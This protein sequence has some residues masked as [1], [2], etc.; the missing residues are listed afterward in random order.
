M[1]DNRLTKLREERG[2]NMKQVAEL[3]EITYTTYVGYEKDKRVFYT[4][5]NEE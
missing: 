5:N 4:L 2:L 1:F 3:L